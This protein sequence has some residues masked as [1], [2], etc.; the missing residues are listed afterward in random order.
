MSQK[1]CCQTVAKNSTVK[2]YKKYWK[3]TALRTDSPCRILLNRMEQQSKKIVQ[4]WKVLILCFIPV[5]YRKKENTTGYILNHTGP[6]P[7]EGKTPLELW[8]GYYATL[9][10]L[11]V[12]GTECYVHSPKQKRYK[13][14]KTSKLG[15]LVGYM[16]EKDSYRIWTPSERKMVMSR[17]VLFK[18]E[19][20]G[21]LHSNITKTESM[22][23]TPHV[24]PSQEIQV[25]QN[26]KSDENNAS[27]SGGSTVSTSGGS[28][29]SN[30]EKYVQ[31]RKSL[32][33]K[34]QPNWMTS[35]EFV[36]L[37]D[38]NQEG[39]CLSPTLYTEAMQ[40][41]EQKQ[42]MKGMNEELA[43]LKENETWE[44]VNRPTNA[45]VIH[46]CWVMCV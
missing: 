43:S 24:T 29:D 41:N 4:L 36:C 12:F 21:N 14:D 11:H 10:H 20:V 17:D 1:L 35:G 26:H 39:Y 40:S 32:R 19:V 23:P 18:P 5:D 22:C 7:V 2:L 27:T 16:G 42:W 9:G 3:S 33:E 45:K 37:A 31:D 38:D 46:N 28:N 30:S 6:T 13:W 8:T 15:R 34:K 25:V 44:L